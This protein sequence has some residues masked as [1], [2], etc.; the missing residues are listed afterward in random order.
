MFYK[1]FINIPGWFSM[2]QG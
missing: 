2:Y 1:L